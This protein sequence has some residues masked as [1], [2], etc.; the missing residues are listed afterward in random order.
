LGFSALRS[1]TGGGAIGGT[2]STGGL[3]TSLGAGFGV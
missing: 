3:M 2:G 1:G